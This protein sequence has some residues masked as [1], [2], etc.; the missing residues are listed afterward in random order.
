MGTFSGCAFFSAARRTHE[1]IRPFE[2][3]RKRS[4]T[5]M[6]EDGSRLPRFVDQSNSVFAQTGDFL[7]LLAQFH[8][9]GLGKT[10]FQQHRIS[11]HGAAVQDEL[12][13]MVHYLEQ[14]A[15]PRGDMPGNRWN[16]RRV[17]EFIMSEISIPEKKSDPS[18]ITALRQ[19]CFIEN[20]SF[21][22]LF[23]TTLK[24]QKPPASGYF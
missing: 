19:N 24:G 15:F 12:F 1:R 22:N 23:F 21:L 2:R 10:A 3:R 11:Q 20:V 14:T 13:W 17:L 8:H 7:Q 18:S 9:A 6:L 4:C 5:A 16:A